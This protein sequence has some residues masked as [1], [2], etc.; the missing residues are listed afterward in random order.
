MANIEQGNAQQLAGRKW[1]P[2]W[3][4]V[5]FALLAM[6]VVGTTFIFFGFEEP[7]ATIEGRPAVT[8]GDV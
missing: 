5:A 3:G 1:N 4:W 2:I 8:Q 6:I 7:R